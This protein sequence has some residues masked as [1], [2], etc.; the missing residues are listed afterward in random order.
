MELYLRLAHLGANESEQSRWPHRVNH[1][2]NIVSSREPQSRIGLQNHQWTTSHITTD[3]PMVSWVFVL[4]L[5]L[6]WAT[7]RRRR[8]Q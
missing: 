6:T 8:Q 5:I 3:Q 2:R 1:Q 7:Q 4:I